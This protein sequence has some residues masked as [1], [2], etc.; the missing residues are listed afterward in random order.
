MKVVVGGTFS[1]LHKGHKKLLEKAFKIGQKV[2]IGL[3]SNEMVDDKH[4]EIEPYN[5]RKQKLERYIKKIKGNTPYRIT[6]IK[7]PVGASLQKDIDAIV[8]SQETKPGA[9]KINKKRH[10]KGLKPLTVITVRMEEA[11]DGEPISSTR[12]R[13]GIID[14]DGNL[15]KDKTP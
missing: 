9:N 3:T 1:P 15:L 8:V 6:K 14:K 10:E 2:V 7:D 5:L 4:G 13:R 12:I 11:E